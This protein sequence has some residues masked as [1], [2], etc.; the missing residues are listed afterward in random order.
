MEPKT[1]EEN[2]QCIKDFVAASPLNFIYL[3]K[4]ATV[5]RADDF[6]TLCDACYWI[7]RRLAYDYAQ[8]CLDGAITEAK[9][10]K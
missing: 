2:I 8:L 6:A 4:L 10:L 9:G 5:M 7:D 1:H 3:N